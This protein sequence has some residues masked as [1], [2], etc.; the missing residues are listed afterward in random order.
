VDVQLTISLVL[1][2]AGAIAAGGVGMRLP[3]GDR[4]AAVLPL[5]VGAGAGVAALAIGIDIVEPDGDFDLAFLTASALGFVATI[6]SL[7][8]LWRWTRHRETA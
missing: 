4:F 5:L 6:G 2:G 7:A 3:A 1:I 8:L